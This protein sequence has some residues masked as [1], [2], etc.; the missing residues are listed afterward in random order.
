[1]S[2]VTKKGAMMVNDHSVKTDTNKDDRRVN[3]VFVYQMMCILI[4]TYYIKAIYLDSTLCQTSELK[5]KAS[6]RTNAIKPSLYQ[7]HA[8]RHELANNTQAKEVTSA[9]VRSLS[10]DFYI[11][12]FA[13]CGTTTLVR[14][15]EKHPETSIKGE[16]CS[17]ASPK[18]SGGSGITEELMKLDPSPAVKRGIK[19]PS[20]IKNQ[21]AI[22]RIKNHSPETHILIG[23]RHPIHFFQSFYNYRVNENHSTSCGISK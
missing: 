16:N 17:F 3:T 7:T 2:G 13:K 12:G 15:F 4:T 20:S 1:M 18:K 21:A 23:F 9:A 11:A 10:L 5:W 14:T 22:K 6:N 19:C 8:E